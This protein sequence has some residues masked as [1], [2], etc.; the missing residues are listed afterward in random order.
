MAEKLKIIP[1]GG[2]GEVG[3]NLTVYEYKEDIIVVD[4]GLGFPDGEM[5]GVDV[6][7]PNVSYLSR[8]IEKIRAIILTH[9]H[10][11]HIGALPYLLQDINAPIFA[12]ALTAA[13]LKGKLEEHHLAKIADIRLMETGVSFKAG[14]FGIEPIHVNHSI[15]G[16]VALAITTPVGVVVHTGD[17]KIDVTPIKSEMID[18]TRFGELGKKGVLLM[19]SDST[20]AE[21]S[22]FSHSERIVGKRLAELFENCKSRIIVTTFSSNVQRIQQVIEVAAR[23]GRKVG[24]TGRSMENMIK[25]ATEMGSIDIPPDTIVEMAKLRNYPRDQIAVITTGSQGEAMSALFRMA[26]SEHKFIDISTGDR[27]VISASAVPGNEKTVS[28]LINL[29]LSRGAEVLYRSVDDELHVSGHACQEELKMLIALVKPRFF[30]PIH[31]EQ[32]HLRTHAALAHSM[33]IE[34]NC[35]VIGD[36]GR[37]VE[38]TKKSIK[39]GGTVQSGR[40]LVDGTGIGDVGSVVLRDRQHLAQDGML[41]VVL[42]LNSED[43]SLLSGP[44]IISR[45]FVYVK[46]SGSLIDEMKSLV[47]DTLEG[48]SLNNITDWATIKTSIKTAL[49][50]FLYKTTKRSPMILPVIMEI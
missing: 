32:R 15:P 36:I 28:R 39:L 22:G 44:D 10:E 23:Y 11:D 26:F 18:L 30:M 49:S 14:C 1:L 40:V 24:I 37:I 25:V 7:I 5:Y 45:G 47:V 19:L 33:G 27:V 17:F 29:L 46:D 38:V 3:K 8:N 12:T 9:G 20:N 48:C 42:S 13:L 21:N 41:V 4:C 16:A 2:L 43:N 34:P 31:G 50:S 35:T 6:V